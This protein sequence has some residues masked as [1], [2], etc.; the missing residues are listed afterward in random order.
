MLTVVSLWAHQLWGRSGL[1]GLHPSRSILKLFGGTDPPA[2]LSCHCYS[3]QRQPPLNLQSVQSVTGGAGRETPAHLPALL[4]FFF[5]VMTCAPLP[6]PLYQCCHRHYWPYQRHDLGCC[7]SV[8]TA[9][10]E[11]SKHLPKQKKQSGSWGGPRRWR[12]QSRQRSLN[13]G[14][15]Q[16]ALPLMPQLPDRL[17]YNQCR[18]Q[19]PTRRVLSRL[20]SQNV[21]KHRT[22]PAL[23]S[24][25]KH[26]RC[27]S[28]KTK[29]PSP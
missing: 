2:V 8:L 5:A 29:P 26:E 10:F 15:C 9:R 18:L 24:H 22:C 27:K 11:S 23:P 21:D 28:G 13:E 1:T 14:H 4:L 19:Q 25:M 20:F 12:Q 3:F 17:L 16:T 7:L 6:H